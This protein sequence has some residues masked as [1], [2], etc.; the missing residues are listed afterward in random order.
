VI[1][2]LDLYVGGTISKPNHVRHRGATTHDSRN[3]ENSF[4]MERHDAF[5]ILRRSRRASFSAPSEPE[6]IGR[7]GDD[8][9]VFAAMVE[10][11]TRK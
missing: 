11:L 10:R 5:V 2:R 7:L 3:L 4:S 9:S 8:A 6:V 1:I